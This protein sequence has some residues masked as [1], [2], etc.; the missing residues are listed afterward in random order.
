MRASDAADGAGL[1]GAAATG[2]VRASADRRGCRLRLPAQV[3]AEWSGTLEE[4]AGSQEF[5]S[6]HP[7]L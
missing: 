1:A 3:T 5:E 6:R 2:P 7:H 4:A